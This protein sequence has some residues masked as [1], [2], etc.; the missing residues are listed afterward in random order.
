MDPAADPEPVGPPALDVPPPVPGSVAPRRVAP[1]TPI[2]HGARAAAI[3]LG[4]LLVFGAEIVA[5]LGGWLVPGFVAVFLV[6]AV[7][8]SAVAYLGWQNLTFWFDEDGDFRLR[9]GVLT[10]QERRLQLSRLQ[11]V[12]VQQPLLA[13]VFGLG[14]VTIE[15]AGSGD[16]R[17][18]LAYLTLAEAEALRAE[19]LARAAGLRPDTATAPEEALLT[20]PTGQL[21]MSLALRGTTVFLLGITIL[22]AATTF[23]SSGPVGLLTLLLFGIP[24]FAVVGEFTSFYGFTVARSADGLRTRGGLLSTRSQTIPPGRVHAVEFVQ[25]LLWRRRGWVRV[26]LNVAGLRRNDDDNDGT[27]T[28]SVLL[29]VATWEQAGDI[30]RRVLPEIDIDALTWSAA[31]VGARRRAWIQ[32]PNLAVAIDDAVF[33]A[34]RGRFVLRV[35]V[36][37]HARVQSVRVT[38][39]PWQRALGLASMHAD[40][41][42]GAVT[43]TALHRTA[44]EARSLAEAEN[45]ALLIATR[46]AGPAHW[47]TGGDGP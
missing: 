35:A 15:V 8:S 19:V 24:I 23:M 4:A 34:R 44:A 17:A 47:M 32:K 12:D 11:T 31:P 38:R 40:S 3:T 28:Q 39:G 10:K 1:I 43:I 16:S 9:K 18:S 21:V 7:V 6:A 45:A 37:P 41:V 26:R 30:V 2:V 42:P 33:A 36:I 29:P 5:D 13:R 20:V 46:S 27:D 14:V 22:I 25:S